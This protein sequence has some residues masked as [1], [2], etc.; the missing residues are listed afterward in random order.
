[1]K[2]NDI[3]GTYGKENFES[4][5]RTQ[6]EERNAG[7]VNKNKI[8]ALK[9]TGGLQLPRMI[10]KGGKCKILTEADIVKQDRLEQVQKGAAQFIE[11]GRAILTVQVQDFRSLI[12]PASLKRVPGHFYSFSSRRISGGWLL[13]NRCLS[14]SI[15]VH[16]CQQRVSGA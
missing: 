11:D 3:A 16:L 9:T 13:S 10:L 12:A 1:V 6:V 15:C 14:V 7:Y 8:A 5:V 4:W 2:V